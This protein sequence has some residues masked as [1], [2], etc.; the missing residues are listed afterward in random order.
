VSEEA[1]DKH[2]AAR[3]ADKLSPSAD[4]CLADWCDVL[5]CDALSAA[6][7][8]RPPP[9]RRC[10]AA[11]LAASQRRCFALLDDCLPVLSAAGGRA[12]RAQARAH[13]AVAE[14]FCARLT[15]EALPTLFPPQPEALLSPATT[16]WLEW[17]GLALLA[18]GLLCYY[19]LL[20][21]SYGVWGGG[22]GGGGARRASGRGRA[23]SARAGEFLLGG[24][25]GIRMAMVRIGIALMR[26]WR[27]RGGAAKRR[28]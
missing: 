12:A 20:A 22:G 24:K 5:Q 19:G 1:L 7:A 25:L 13:A 9:A 16:E 26:R 14:R 21:R 10:A 17:L 28:A 3:H 4:V 23:A 6:A 15:C 8:A 18:C 2:L 11:A 27:R